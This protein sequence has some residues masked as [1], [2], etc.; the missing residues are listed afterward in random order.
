[1][2]F[3][4]KYRL[5]VIL[6][7]LVVSCMLFVGW[8]MEQQELNN[9][10]LVFKENV[11]KKSTT[12][13]N[14][15][16]SR[17]VALQRMAHRWERDSGTSKYAFL[18]DAE[19]YVTDLAGFQ[20]IEWVNK[21]FIVEWVVPLKGNEAAQGL[22][23]AAEKRR[24]VALVEARDKK[25]VVISKP[26]D[27]VQGGKGFL[28]YVPLFNN[29]TF[30]GFVLAVLK[31]ENWLNSILFNDTSS[32]DSEQYNTSVYFDDEL[33]YER[34][35]A[36]EMKE[37]FNVQNTEKIVSGREFTINVSPTKNYFDSIH[38]GIPVL[39][40]I[41]GVI[42]TLLI[43]ITLMVLQ[44]ALRLNEK[45]RLSNKELNQEVEKHLRAKNALTIERQRL[46]SFIE[47]TNVGT[48]EWN[49]QTGETEFNERWANIIG[50]TLDEL[51]PISIDT[52]LKY[53]HP[54]DLNISEQKLAECIEGVS[55]FYSC[56]VR[57]KHKNG[58]WIWV[59]D[60]GKIFSWDS[61][62]K[63]KNMFGTHTDINTAKEEKLQLIEM[64][65]Q[66]ENTSAIANSLTAQAELA[67]I[68]KSEFLA[69]M[70]HEIRTPM[71]GVTCM[72]ELVL[73]SN[74]TDEQK[75][76]V[77]IIK[78]SGEALIS[79][80]NDILDFS[81]I[82]AGK[83]EID[84]YPFDFYELINSIVH[85]VE[86]RAEDKKIFLEH[87]IA[88]NV[89]QY[90]NSDPNRIRQILM[91]LLGNA[92]KFTEKGGISL[93]VAIERRHDEGVTLLFSVKDTGM[94]I[95][96]KKLDILFDKFSQVD[97]EITRNY[98]GTG[99]GL[100]ISKQL[101][102]LLG[103][104]VGVASVIGEGSTFSFTI[105]GK[106]AD[107][108]DIESSEAEEVQQEIP[109]ENR[110]AFDILVVEDN[111]TNRL[112][113]QAVLQK[114]GYAAEEAFDGIDA[115]EKMAVKKYDLVFMDVQMP[116]LDGFGATKRIR[117]LNDSKGTSSTSIIAMTANAMKGDKE[118]C[119]EAGMNDYISK[120]ISIPA[121]SKVLSKWLPKKIS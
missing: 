19:N 52:W 112:I 64:N 107:K 84:S 48:W 11:E 78:N 43:F 68:A 69:N 27:L 76:Y 70:S 34:V 24:R 20:A 109:F 32:L 118:E 113:I 15:L 77:S 110:A 117:N 17:I 74:I 93:S 98:G 40:T 47:G 96:K 37:S 89:P 26:I 61:N 56:E 92:F 115:M 6:S 13:I 55:E 65:E 60:H 54:D 53:S 29:N 95:P 116:R 121:V 4:K 12:I 73:D 91:N 44:N 99:L 2:I 103:G 67:S 30:D 10:A 114:L 72:A 3:L 7:G 50:Y 14:D 62:G 111:I 16:Q 120:P 101:S 35:H 82:E 1:M 46:T 104:G 119:L 88:E 28:V 49:I 102:E 45:V 75:K 31:C 71:N 23:L 21:D 79:L 36:T 94:G 97:K 51:S 25:S 18:D 42:I 57:M 87:T 90:I 41:L 33:I 38:S 9:N 58:Q 5:S 22:N 108:K 59:H 106:I 80:I 85:S 105:H 86:Y 63:P 83:L 39:I 8:L 100:A 66:L 81:K